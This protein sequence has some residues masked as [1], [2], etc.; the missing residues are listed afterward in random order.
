MPSIVVIFQLRAEEVRRYWIPRTKRSVHLDWF[1][2][3]T[4]RHDDNGFASSGG[5]R[6]YL[7]GDIVPFVTVPI[8][9]YQ[10]AGP[11]IA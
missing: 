11:G 8:E 3:N 2:N 6:Q 7:T 9:R 1:R 5:K 4:A 10:P